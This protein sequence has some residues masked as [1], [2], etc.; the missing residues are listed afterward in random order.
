MKCFGALFFVAND[1]FKSRTYLTYLLRKRREYG[2]DLVG[3]LGIHMVYFLFR[4][5][6]CYT[7]QKFQEAIDNL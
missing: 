4:R 3:D 7:A 2:S 6:S 1:A 5:I